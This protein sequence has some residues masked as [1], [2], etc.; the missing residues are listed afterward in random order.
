MEHVIDFTRYG[1]PAQ[2]PQDKPRLL[3]EL[4]ERIGS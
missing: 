4:S 2:E 3:E 1:P